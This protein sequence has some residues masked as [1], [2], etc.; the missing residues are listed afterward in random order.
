MMHICFD[1]NINDT[2]A[3]LVV[4]CDLIYR[5]EMIGP[6]DYT[7]LTLLFMMMSIRMTHP[8]IH[9]TLAPGL[10]DGT[11]TLPALE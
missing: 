7:K 9:E 11:L 3:I 1:L 5:A 4:V 2:D 10:M 6:V 8:S